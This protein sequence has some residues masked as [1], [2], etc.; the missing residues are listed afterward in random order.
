MFYPALPDKDMSQT[1]NSLLWELGGTTE[2]GH[3]LPQFMTGN[4]KLTQESPTQ[5]TSR[6]TL[7]LQQSAGLTFLPF[8]EKK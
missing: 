3:R 7:S 5:F 4:C 8:G 6:P 2:Q 1:S